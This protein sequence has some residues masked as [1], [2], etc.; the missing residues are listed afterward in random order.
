MNRKHLS[1]TLAILLTAA[2][3]TGC[4]EQNKKMEDLPQDSSENSAVS[5]QPVESKIG[6]SK[7]YAMGTWLAPIPKQYSY[8]ILSAKTYSTLKAA[9]VNVKDLVDDNNWIDGKEEVPYSQSGSLKSG[10]ILLL[11]NMEIRRD[12]SSSSDMMQPMVSFLSLFQT[13]ELGNRD[14]AKFKPGLLYNSKAPAENREKNYDD[15]P[16][17]SKAGETEQFQV[18]WIIPKSYVKAG[19][20]SI[21]MQTTGDAVI[22]KIG[23]DTAK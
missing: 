9:G 20:L 13:S 5:A 1:A 21:V 11:L 7:I 3:L 19:N 16:Q 22:L 10:N 6:N 4:A 15:L 14:K 17:L 23:D 8:R 2:L 12:A 18:G